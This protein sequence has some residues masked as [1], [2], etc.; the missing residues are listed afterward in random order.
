M[1]SERVIHD[2]A[3]EQRPCYYQHVSFELSAQVSKDPPW[4]LSC[5]HPDVSGRMES[6]RPS[7]HCPDE[8]PAA[9]VPEPR[10]PASKPSRLLP[11][12]SNSH[13]VALS[14]LSN[15]Q[16]QILCH[17]IRDVAHSSRSRATS[18]GQAHLKGRHKPR[19]SRDSQ[20]LR[21]MTLIRAI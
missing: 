18:L 7:S 8:D 10:P 21:S 17:F 1:G 12:G 14:L 19:Q 20:E 6:S 16:G 5:P 13:V 2:L 11:L 4:S 9:R 15:L 3:T